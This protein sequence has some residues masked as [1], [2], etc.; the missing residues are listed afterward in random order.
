MNPIKL[1]WATLSN[2]THIG[3]YYGYRVHNENLRKYANQH[4][5][6]EV[7]EDWEKADACLYITTPENFNN[8]PP[9][10]TFLFTMFE[11]TSKLPEVYIQNLQKADFIITP[12]HWAKDLFTDYFPSDKTFVVPHGVEEVFTYCKRNVHPKCFRFLW[13]G[14]AN[15]RK[16]YQELILIWDKLG[17]YR[18]PNIELYIKTTRVPNITIQR[19]RN[20]ILDS[21]NLSKEELVKVYHS[22]NCFVFPSRGEGFGLTL[23]EAMA[24]GL[25][26]IATGRSGESEFFD[27]KVGYPIKYSLGMSKV[28][29]WTLGDLGETEV[30]YP[31][32]ADL[33][34]NMFQVVSNYRKALLKGKEAS[35]RIKLDFTWEKSAEKLYLALKQ[36]LERSN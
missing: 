14:A 27:K 7:V 16:G 21:R 25:P 17:L 32:P 24:T 22:A 23:A 15:P 28:K 8:R 6:I 19:N 2:E 13:V 4:P 26:C 34:N 33:A 29:S 36:G 31:D 20:V 35:I 12:S 1:F 10:P 18:I 3:N 9:K 5:M 30:A 11:G